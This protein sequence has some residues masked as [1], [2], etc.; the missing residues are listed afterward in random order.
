MGLKLLTCFPGRQK[1]ALMIY[2]KDRREWSVSYARAWAQNHV[3]CKPPCCHRRPGHSPNSHGRQTWI[4]TADLSSRG[5]GIGSDG[6]VSAGSDAQCSSVERWYQHERLLIMSECLRWT[7]CSGYHSRRENSKKSTR[8][9]VGRAFTLECGCVAVCRFGRSGK[10]FSHRPSCH[11]QSSRAGCA[12]PPPSG[13]PL[14]HRHIR[15]CPRRGRCWPTLPPPT[16]AVHV[17]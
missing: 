4:G 15:P 10:S 1:I 7:K 13:S 8:K 12:S 11:R 6:A 3:N 14:L 2:R 16:K 9:T 17:C 5:L